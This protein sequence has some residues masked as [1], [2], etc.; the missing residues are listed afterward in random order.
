[1]CAQAHMTRYMWIRM[2]SKRALTN[3]FAVS[4]LFLRR[5]D[6]VAGSTVVLLES[7]SR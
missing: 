2:G 1:M 5:Y 6:A 4:C 3:V 7:I